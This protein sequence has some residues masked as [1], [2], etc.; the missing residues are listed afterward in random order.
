MRVAWRSWMEKQVKMVWAAPAVLAVAGVAF[1]LGTA[2]GGAPVATTDRATIEKIVRDYILAHP[3]II[4][5]AINGMQ[6]REVTKLLASN[7]KDIE[8]PF[9][10]AVAKSREAPPSRPR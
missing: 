9:A 4:P 3:E 1:A 5:E 10:G 7:R 6:S 2:A 8:T